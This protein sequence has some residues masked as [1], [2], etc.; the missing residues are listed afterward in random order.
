MHRTGSITTIVP[1]GVFGGRAESEV[2]CLVA[3]THLDQPFAHV[4]L[5]FD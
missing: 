4:M 2:S 1:H 3:D 5:A